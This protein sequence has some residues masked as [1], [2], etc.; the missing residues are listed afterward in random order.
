MSKEIAVAVVRSCDWKRT[1]KLKKAEKVF[2]G[3]SEKRKKQTDMSSLEQKTLRSGGERSN[4]RWKNARKGEKM[5]QQGKKR[6]KAR[7][8]GMKNGC[9]NGRERE[10]KRTHRSTVS[11]RVT[12]VFRAQN[13]LC[14][15]SVASKARVKTRK[16]QKTSKKQRKTTDLK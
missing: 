13:R 12:N 16:S 9:R 8:N 11:V 7:K 1:G 6:A 3:S 5:L 15:I 2:F 14:L 4:K 10:E